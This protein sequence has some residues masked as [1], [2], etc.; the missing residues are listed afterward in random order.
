VTASIEDVLASLLTE[1][2]TPGRIAQAAHVKSWWAAHR[3]VAS[4]TP[5]DR[6]ALALH[7][8]FVA[9]CPAFAFASGYQGPL[10]ARRAYALAARPVIADASGDGSGQAKRGRMAI[11]RSSRLARVTPARRNGRSTMTRL[12]ALAALLG[13][14]A[15][16]TGALAAHGLK[17]ILT[18]QELAW[19]KTAAD[20]HLLHAL[21]M[22]V[23]ALYAARAETVTRLMRVSVSAFG[24]GILLFSGSL[25]TMALTDVLMLG[26][27][28]PF[29][30]VALLVGW[31]TFALAL[32]RAPRKAS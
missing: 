11:T 27:V 14:I 16:A 7:A 13:G 4:E 26:A 8:G 31:G 19:W 6:V 25:Y 18:A 1:A 5:E 20:Y 15:V 24:I 23:A 9:T 32:Y 17:P 28:T 22:L 12:A 3:V 10:Q 29:G 2:V 30:G 21:A